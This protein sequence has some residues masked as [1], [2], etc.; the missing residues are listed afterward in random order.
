MWETVVD[1][2]TMKGKLPAPAALACHV[3]FWEEEV[4]ASW[5]D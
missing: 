3:V 4:S 5:A 2:K 1:V